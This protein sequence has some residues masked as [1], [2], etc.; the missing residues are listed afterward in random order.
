MQA[1]YNL[2][3][4]LHEGR[5]VERNP[6]EAYY[7]VKVAALQGDERALQGIAPL[8]AALSDTQKKDTDAQAAAWMEQ[9]KKLQ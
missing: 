8:A 6:Q 1:Q 4:L 9:V 2:G 5:G 7:W 3:L